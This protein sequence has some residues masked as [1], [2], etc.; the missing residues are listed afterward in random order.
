MKVWLSEWYY[1]FHNYYIIFHILNKSI[2]IFG[3]SRIIQ[4]KI[5]VKYDLQ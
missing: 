2:L 5:D 1:I 3:L 4:I